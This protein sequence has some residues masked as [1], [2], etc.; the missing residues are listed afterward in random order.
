[1]TGD[2]LAQR[3]E[4][5]MQRKAEMIDGISKLSWPR[6]YTSTPETDYLLSSAENARR[7]MAAKAQIEAGEGL[8]YDLSEFGIDEPDAGAVHDDAAPP[9]VAASHSCTHSK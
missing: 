6:D 1:M 7:L 5:A 2:D 3:R 4:A 9:A 8:T